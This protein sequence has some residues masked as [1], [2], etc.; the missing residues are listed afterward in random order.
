MDPILE[1][2][3]SEHPFDPYEQ[4]ALHLGQDPN[5]T[6]KS[7]RGPT[8]LAEMWT[9]VISLSYDNLQHIRI[10]PIDIDIDIV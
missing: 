1:E 6:I 3:I 8:K 2:E 5:L 10:G 7:K 9:K 4:T